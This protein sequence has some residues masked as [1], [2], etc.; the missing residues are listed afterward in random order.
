MTSVCMH[1]GSAYGMICDDTLHLLLCRL[2]RPSVRGAFDVL[3]SK[4]RQLLWSL[5]GGLLG[6][7]HCSC[8]TVALRDKVLGGI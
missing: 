5:A 3:D 2:S 4:R 1:I 6:E 8:C 7:W